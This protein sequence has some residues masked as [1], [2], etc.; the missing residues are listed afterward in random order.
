[1]FADFQTV[2]VEVEP[3]I[4][5]N[6]VK[7]GSGPPLLLLHGY[8]QTHTIWHKIAPQLAERFTVVASDLRGYGDSSKPKGLSD[9]SNYSKR[10]MAQDQVT[11]MQQLGFE[12]FYLAGHDRGARVSHR[13]AADHSERVLKLA[14]LDISPTLTMYTQTSE[15]FARAYW[16][17]FFLIQNPP[18]PETLISANPELYLRSRMSRGDIGLTPFT[19]EAWR[20]YVRCFD[21][22]AI[23]GSCEDYRAAAT[24]DLTHDRKDRTNGKKLEQPVLLLWG[25]KGAIETCFHPIQ[26]WQEVAHDVQGHSLPCGH[27][28]PEEK[29]EAVLEAFLE[30]FGG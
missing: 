25:A 17:W 20:E 29:P 6:A 24:M 14:L 21:T 8:P 16:H 30:F 4:T 12:K 13:L 1:M 26:D 5:I 22:N 9:H 23:H 10:V 11:L 27:Y 28:L 7:G 18:L 2:R 3:G 19:N 15:V